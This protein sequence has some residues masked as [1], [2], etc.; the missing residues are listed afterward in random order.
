MPSLRGLLPTG[1][2]QAAALLAIL[3]VQLFGFLAQAQ[4]TAT[5]TSST[6]APNQRIDAQATTSYGDSRLAG[7]TVLQSNILSAMSKFVP[8]SITFFTDLSYHA[9]AWNSGAGQRLF[10]QVTAAGCNADTTQ[11]ETLEITVNSWKAGG[12]KTYRAVETG[13]STGVFRVDTGIATQDVSNRSTSAARM[14]GGAAHGVM[15][16]GQ[17]DAGFA[18]CSGLSLATDIMIDPGGVVFDSA[19]GEPVPGVT[20]RLIDVTGAGNGGAAGGAARVFGYDGTTPAPSEVVTGADGRYSFP[21]VSPSEYRVNVTAPAA[22]RFPSARAEAQFPE[23]RA[24]SAPGSY[25]GTFPVN[26][27]TGA[28]VLDV[29]LDPLPHGLSLQKTASRT[30]AELGESVEYLVTVKNVG[31]VDLQAVRVADTLPIGFAYVPGSARLDG[32]AMAEPAGGKGPAL[33]FAAGRIEIGASRLLRYRARVGAGALHGDGINRAQARSDAPVATSSNIASAKV[34]VEAGVFSDKAI[35]LGTVFADCNANGVQDPQEPGAPV[36]RL[37]LEDGSFVV[38]DGAGR[39]SFYGVSARTHALKIDASSL[40]AGAET[41]AISQ[42][43]AGDGNSR[44]IDAHRGELHRADFA[45]AGCSSGLVEALRVRRVA[46]GGQERELSTSVKAE[47]KAGAATTI[48]DVRSLPAQ[49]LVGELVAAAPARAAGEPVAA[50]GVS[51]VSKADAKADAGK[52]AVTLEALAA[53]S[54]NQLAFVD[55]QDGQTVSLSPKSLRIKGRKGAVIALQVNGTALGD[56]RVGQRVLAEETQAELREYIGVQLQRGDNTL[57]LTEADG[58]GRVRATRVLHL[59]VP[60]DVARIVVTPAQARAEADGQSRLPVRIEAFD[61]RGALI[62]ERIAVSLQTTAGQWNERDLDNHQ[63]GVQTFIEGGATSLELMAPAAPGDAQLQV[64]AGG[65]KGEARVAFGPILRPMMAVGVIEGAFNLRKLDPR[66][67]VAARKD[68]GFEEQLQQFAG[69]DEKSVGARAAVFLKGKV[70]GD[71]LLTLGYDSDKS[72]DGLFRDIQPDAFYPVYGDS[73]VRG[74]DAQSTGKLYVR[75]EKDKSYLLYGDFTTQSVVP[76]RQLGAYQRSLS[77][78]KQHYEADGIAANAFASHDSTRQV[79]TERR[80][81]GTS[82]PYQIGTGEFIAN[83]EKIEIIVRDRNQPSLIIKATALARFTDYDVEPLTGRLLLRAPVASLDADLNP[84]S[85]RITFEADQGGPKFWVAGV[86]AQVQLS[87]TIEVGGSFV[88]DLNP[89]EPFQLSSVNTTVKLGADSQLIAEV[90]R[91]DSKNQDADARTGNAERFEF[92]HNGTALKARLYAARSDIGF[93][94]KSATITHGHSEAGAKVSYAFDERTR[95]TLDGL[96]TADLTTAAKRDGVLIGV[97]RSFD[98]GTKVEFGAR[99]VHDVSATKDQASTDTTSLRAKLTTTVPGLPA[100]T[101]FVEAEQDVRDSSKRLFALGGDYQLA[102]GGR[103]YLRHELIS[104]LTGPY[105]LDSAQRH[106][107]TVLGVDAEVMQEGRLFSEYRGR[108]AF[109]GRST[110][111]AIGLRNR[112][113]LA[114]GLRLNT[115]F[116]RVQALSGSREGM[117]TA[118][119]GAIEYTANPLWKATGRLELRDGLTSRSLLTTLG[120]ARKLDADWTFL[121]K[122]VFALTQDKATSP[123]VIDTATPITTRTLRS[124]ERLQLGLAYRDSAT[125]RVNALARYEFKQERGN[126]MGNSTGDGARSVHTVS[127]H[128]DY[129]PQ[130]ALTL[131][132]HVAAKWLTDAIDGQRE[133]SNAQLIGGRVTYE[134]NAKWDVGV[135]ANVLATDILK[136]RQTGIGGE[137]GYQVQKNL[138][139]SAGYNVTGFSDRDLSADNYTNRGVYVRLRFKFDETLFDRSPA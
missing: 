24:V 46:L 134:M 37:Y 72:R 106:N 36:V 33:S 138:W 74:F 83:S 139:V 25:G 121:G 48:G 132:G 26:V 107:S 39:F 135:A 89:L 79:V 56:D 35:V 109:E 137:V 88:K 111:A 117:A 34:K 68:D 44:F 115:S 47:L 50:P 98:G 29:P 32:A 118:A 9:R 16:G 11:V 23:S 49:G 73:S 75:I 42:R 60:G 54:D 96:H 13:A 80:G 87:D 45:L 15:P 85:L 4:T 6:R 127:A 63:P 20:V 93:D 19:T 10:L 78:I 1:W 69:G 113:L 21:K 100:A 129:Q 82:G 86:D 124:Q 131:T 5:T 22:Y 108:E 95:L 18:G 38:T 114:E 62:T 64:A 133:R 3:A 17:V 28:V 14:A 77:G 101:V 110:E 58:F 94:N 123:P 55:L 130:R 103:V 71:Y 128:G 40:P 8:P 67:M 2:L 30:T 27:S 70:K 53:S 90:A 119:T 12:S 66:A 122:N 112:W 116:E 76:A 125:N 126:S 65:V 61:A 104:S 99:R 136:S 51:G 7:P 57:T 120:I 52:P 31:E 102:N 105:A 81:D 41:V 97:E 59:V 84:V 91:A 43:H 92:Q